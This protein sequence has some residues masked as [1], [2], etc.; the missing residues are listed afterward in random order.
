MQKVLVTGA[1]GVIGTLLWQALED[2]GWSVWPFDTAFAP[3]TVGH[4]DI[5][6]SVALDDALAECDGIIHL[7]AVSRV[8]DGER[9]PDACRSI[10]IEG[11]RTLVESAAASRRRLWI[12]FMSSCQVYGSPAQLPVIESDPI[13]PVNIYGR[14]KA[15]GEQLI[16]DAR[17]KGLRT[18]ILRLPNVY[19][20]VKDYPD[21]AVPAFALRAVQGQPL[22]VTG[23]S[24]LFDF[25]HVSDAVSGIARTACRLAEGT[26]HLP[27]MN[28]ATG[29]GISLGELARLAK[30]LAVSDSCIIEGMPRP[31]DTLGYVG[32]PRRASQMLGWEAHIPIEVGL[33][34]LISA[35]SDSATPSLLS[36]DVTV[37]T[38]Q[39]G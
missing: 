17:A 20:S 35:F 32:N 7:A 10:N 24:Q 30:E 29:R 1:R 14:S 36:G 28:L 27:S 19:G 8:I 9:D 6:D 25:L 4:G 13:A 21:R 2:S 38:R 37:E 3:G 15:E 11:T 5:R 31:F 33:A 23:A 39:I 34:R 12:L 18:A 22:Q 16:D 26:P